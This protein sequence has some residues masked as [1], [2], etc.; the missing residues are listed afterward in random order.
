[1]AWNGSGE[2]WKFMFVCLFGDLAVER[3]LVVECIYSKLL[4]G[5]NFSLLIYDMPKA[6]CMSGF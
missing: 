6:S 1:M 5:T 2:G 4:S 3:G